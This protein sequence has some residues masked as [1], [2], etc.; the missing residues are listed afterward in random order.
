[1]KHLIFIASVLLL[2][3]SCNDSS[4]D[5]N[6]S[7]PIADLS[8]EYVV[9][10]ISCRQIY[11]EDKCKNMLNL[12][13]TRY[14]ANRFWYGVHRKKKVPFSSICMLV[15]KKNNTI[16]V[17]Q[18]LKCSFQLDNSEDKTEIKPGPVVNDKVDII[19]NNNVGSIQN[20]SG[21]SINNTPDKQIITGNLI[22]WEK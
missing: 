6:S 14:T 3:I 12:S 2:L 8:Y 13:Y 10:D 16:I 9:Q 17:G 18:K 1:M 20:N 21:S 7:V 4:N 15:P 11:G 22:S 19:I 5:F